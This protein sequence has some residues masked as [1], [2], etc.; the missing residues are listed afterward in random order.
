MKKLFLKC[1]VF[2]TFAF[3]MF[4]CSET[5]GLYND[6]DSFYMKKVKLLESEME[7]LCEISSMY[8]IPISIVD[9][10]RPLDEETYNKL[11]HKIQTIVNEHNKGE[12]YII[13]SNGEVFIRSILDPESV[14]SAP[15]E[16]IT[17]G[18]CEIICN[19]AIPPQCV[20]S[21]NWSSSGGT[22]VETN[23][24]YYITSCVVNCTIG[25]EYLTFDGRFVLHSEP[26]FS[27]V[28]HLSGHHYFNGEHCDVT[29]VSP[30]YIYD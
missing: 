14:L 23:N 1:F 2:C 10:Y 25:S 26:I 12:M 13:L 22:L 15:T 3:G 8:E 9:N 17:P 20:L 28:F 27:K 16:H 18:S 29:A 24:P 7:R 11:T 6:E 21:V 5:I 30:L 19:S 4:S